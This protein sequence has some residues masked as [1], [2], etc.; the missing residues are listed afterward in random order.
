MTEHRSPLPDPFAL[1]RELISQSERQ[2]NT[3]LNE[4]MA[5]DQ[6]SQS[7]GRFMDLYV[8]MQKSMGE[9]MGR[10]LAALNM[11]TR[12]DVLALN[13]RLLAIEQRLASLERSLGRLGAVREPDRDAPAADALRPPRTKKPSRE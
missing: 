9:T 3:L 12:A 8:A 11:P 10:Y 4:A 6:F 1:W 2:W 13:D 5:T 7:M